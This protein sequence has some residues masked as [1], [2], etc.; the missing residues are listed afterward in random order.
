MVGD[1]C[2][3]ESRRQGASWP[4][5]ESFF[6]VTLGMNCLQYIFHRLRG[7][8]PAAFP[9]RIRF[10]NRELPSM[11]LRPRLAEWLNSLMFN[12]ILASPPFAAGSRNVDGWLRRGQTVYLGSEP[13]FPAIRSGAPC[14]PEPEV[15]WV[16]LPPMRRFSKNFPVGCEM[17]E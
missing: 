6:Q 9:G 15:V 4:G 14:S 13:L 10:L 5:T 11:R 16:M 17:I 2:Q 1:P 7:V 12:H 3:D 8:A